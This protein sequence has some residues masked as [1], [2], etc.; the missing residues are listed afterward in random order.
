MF[1]SPEPMDF[2]NGQ[3]FTIECPTGEV[4]VSSLAVFGR[5]EQGRCIREDEF[6]G[7]S[8]DV[9]FLAD[10]WCSGRSNCEASIP[11]DELDA[12]NTHCKSYLRMYMKMEYTCVNGNILIFHL[13]LPFP[14]E[15]V[16]VM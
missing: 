10:I 8:N 3:I 7:C 13:S 12:A 11:N 15:T 5:M 16:S 1:S 14:F 6:I 2:C 4:I 9:L